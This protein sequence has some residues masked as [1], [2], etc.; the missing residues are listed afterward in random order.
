MRVLSCVGSH[1]RTRPAV[2]SPTPSRPCASHAH[3]PAAVTGDERSDRLTMKIRSM[4]HCNGRGARSESGSGAGNARGQPFQAPARR[5]PAAA[6]P[7]DQIAPCWLCVLHVLRCILCVCARAVCVCDALP[8][9]GT[10]PHPFLPLLSGTLDKLLRVSTLK[11]R[12]YQLL[13]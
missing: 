6:E 4:T 12:I 10:Q 11:F 2:R 1:S 5:E 9:F 8:T 3:G 7:G 13:C